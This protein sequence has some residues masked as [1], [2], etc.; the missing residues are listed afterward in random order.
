[1]KRIVLASLACALMF[2]LVGC[3]DTT[4]TG[5]QDVSSAADSFSAS[6]Q[7]VNDSPNYEEYLEDISVEA[8]I[9]GG[10]SQAIVTITN[11]SSM[12]FD[13][14]VHVRFKN[15]RGKFV[16]NDSIFVEDLPAGDWTFARI[17]ISETAN[18]EFTYSFG[19]YEFTEGYASDSGVL[20]EEV[21][22]EL[23]DDFKIGFGGGD[24][25]TWATSWYGYVTKIEVFSAESTRYAVITVRSDADSESVSRIGNAIFGNYSKEYELMRILVVDEDGNTVFDRSK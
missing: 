2:S 12:T 15:A 22:A 1:M 16:G 10:L 13:G 5:S 11:S 21:S 14:T 25:P 4:S 17:K 24:D 9:D 23:A 7:G 19:N 6:V 18:V 3:G 8:K 20:D